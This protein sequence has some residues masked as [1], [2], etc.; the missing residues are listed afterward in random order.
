M[1]SLD[2]N[3]LFATQANGLGG[4]LCGLVVA[5]K[6]AVPEHNI[7]IPHLPAFRVKRLPSIIFVV[8]LVLFFTRLIHVSFYIET[9]GMVASWVF[10][11]YYKVQDG[12]RGDRSETFSFASFFPDAMEPMLKPLSTVVYRAMVKIKALPPLPPRTLPLDGSD[13]QRLPSSTRRAPTCTMPSVVV[14]SRC[15]RWMSG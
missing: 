15:V 11:R 6:Q 8:H 5:F 13:R 7:Q 10:L 3:Y 2:I 12:I 4:L 1:S 14:H 9:Y